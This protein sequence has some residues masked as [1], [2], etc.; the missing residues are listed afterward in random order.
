MK[1]RDIWVEQ[2]NGNNKSTEKQRW[3]CSDALTVHL[4]HIKD[5]DISQCIVEKK[6]TARQPKS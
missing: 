1:R 2:I 3:H 4:D 6:Q 5:I